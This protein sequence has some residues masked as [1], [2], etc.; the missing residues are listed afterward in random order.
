MKM[1][2]NLTIEEIQEVMQWAELYK[3][4]KID[5][6]LFGKNEIPKEL[7][8]LVITQ[9]EVR[10]KWEKKFPSLSSKPFFV[11]SRRV[12]EQSSSEATASFKG[13]FIEEENTLID[14][15]GGAGIDFLFMAQKAHK[16]YYIEYDTGTALASRYN[17][18]AQNIPSQKFTF[19]TGDSLEYLPLLQKSINPFFYCDPARRTDTGRRTFL[20]DDISP[21]PL[22]VRDNIEHYF[23]KT[24]SKLLIKLSP[25]LDIQVL[26]KNIPEIQELYIVSVRDE[27]KEL[28]AFCPEIPL[29]STKSIESTM[30]TAID[31]SREGETNELFSFTILEEQSTPCEYTGNVQ[32]YLYLPSAM[33]MKAGAFKSIAL[34]YGLKALHPNS[35]LYTSDLYTKDFTGKIF[36]VE[37]V[38]PYAKDKLKQ[39]GKSYSKA[40][41]SVRNFPLSAEDLMHRTKIKEGTEFRIFA[42]TLFPAKAVFI[43]CRETLKEIY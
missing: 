31:L 18:N 3:E 21:N 17:I 7:R 35:H 16:S 38:V 15:T 9:L 30:I 27:V 32:K 43:V 23:P 42:T 40:S 6:L 33:I 11:P 39:L 12:F 2:K 24:S 20:L 14:L 1:D 8:S 19:Y 4:R 10:K 28:L 29:K 25:L 13:R 37:T 36:S 26:L 5:R 41:F 22:R 34:R